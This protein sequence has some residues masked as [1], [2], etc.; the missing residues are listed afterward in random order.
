MVT[1]A[2]PALPICP[3][4]DRGPQNRQLASAPCLVDARLQASTLCCM[5]L[6][7]YLTNRI[8]Q[9]SIRCVSSA[10]TTHFRSKAAAVLHLL[11][12]SWVVCVFVCSV[13]TVR[14]IDC[15]LIAAN[16]NVSLLYLPTEYN[17]DCQ[18][19]D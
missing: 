4:T 5:M 11:V 7:R 6:R 16:L 18:V 2:S 12:F 17:P 8:R 19:W 10:I 13:T 3:G 1:S 15:L 9:V 14:L